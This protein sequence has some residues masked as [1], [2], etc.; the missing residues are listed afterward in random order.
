LFLIL[1]VHSVCLMNEHSWS[2]TRFYRGKVSRSRWQAEL[3]RE[4]VVSDW[5]SQRAWEERCQVEGE[6]YCGPVRGQHM[7]SHACVVNK[8]KPPVFPCVVLNY[9][10][11]QLA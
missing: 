11:T 4:A 6:W 8:V 2:G 10:I 1:N 7:P 9:D 3:I 5:F